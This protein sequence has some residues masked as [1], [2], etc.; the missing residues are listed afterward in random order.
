MS[1][2][3]DNNHWV[4][5]ELI[6]GDDRRAEA[7][8]DTINKS[9]EEL[10]P[11]LFLLL[12]ADDNNCRWWAT[13]ALAKIGHPAAREGLLCALQD[14]APA[15]RQCG[16]LGLA[17]QPDFRAIPILILALGD[18]DRLFA[19]LA[20]N[21]LA[22]LGAEAVPPLAEALRSEDPGI[23]IEAA[24]AMAG[25]DHPSIIPHLFNALEDPSPL[26]AYYAEAG[27]EKQ[28]AGMVFFRL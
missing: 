9:N 19:R 3:S 18:S 27:L 6:S 22:A 28:N 17:A 21:A 23:R 25:L 2:S 5:Q 10:I 26:V 4:I 16:A 8:L 20:S 14:G 11:E 7:A 24:R 12:D 15:V 13:A 1:G